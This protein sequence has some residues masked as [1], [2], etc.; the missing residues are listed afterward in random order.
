MA[1][2]PGARRR[3]LSAQDARHGALPW[4]RRVKGQLDNCC[5]PCRSDYKKAHY[6]AKHAAVGRP[7]WSAQAPIGR[8]SRAPSHRLLPR[9]SLRR[10][11]GDRSAGAGVRSPRR[12]VV[13][14]R[15]GPS[16]AKLGGDS[17]RDLEVRSMLCELPSPPNCL[18][19][20]LGSCGCSSTVEPRPSKA[21]TRVQLPS[22]A[23]SVSL[24]D[25][26]AR[27]REHPP[28]PPDPGIRSCCLL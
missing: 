16:G 24:A 6:A 23:L 1:D 4:R 28:P 8:P 26:V 19:G 5:R 10:L 17:R 12:Q 25:M 9:P 20:W 15:P 27:R 14:H 3:L 2:L 18:S 22:P 21:I 13:R 11:R 7:C